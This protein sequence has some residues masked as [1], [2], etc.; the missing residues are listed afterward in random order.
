[1][2]RR[3]VARRGRARGRTPLVTACVLMRQVVAWDAD[4]RPVYAEPELAPASP[5]E[6]DDLADALAGIPEATFAPDEDAE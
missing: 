6:L 5:G 4:G 1:M 3:A 2:P